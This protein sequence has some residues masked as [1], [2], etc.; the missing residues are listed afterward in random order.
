MNEKIRGLDVRDVEMDEI[1]GFV[2][3]KE[4]HKLSSEKHVAEIGTAYCFVGME[5]NT[6]LVL[7]HHLGK[8]DIP[9]TD[10]LLAHILVYPPATHHEDTTGSRYGCGAMPAAV[11]MPLASAEN[12]PLGSS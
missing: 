5:R 3:K 7:A 4:G 9:S 10:C 11:R 6:K 2:Q 12:W 8:G 1:W